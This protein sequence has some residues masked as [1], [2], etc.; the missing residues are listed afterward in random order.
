MITK[1]ERRN[2]LEMFARLDRVSEFEDSK[3]LEIDLTYRDNELA[4]L[5]RDYV[6]ATRKL[7][8]AARERLER[9]W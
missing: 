3:V 6:E 8:T 5:W 2:Y 9:K 7:A 1:N 4:T